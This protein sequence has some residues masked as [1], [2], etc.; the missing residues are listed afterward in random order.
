[1]KQKTIAVITSLVLV[2][3]FIYAGCEMTVNDPIR[4]VPIFKPYI[5]VHPASQSLTASASAQTV[6]L[7]VQV[8]EW[9]PLDGSLSFQWY[10]F[11]RLE[12]FY[13][14]QAQPVGSGQFFSPTIASSQDGDRY[15]YY[16]V[17]TNTNADAIGA[18]SASTVSDVAVI[19]FSG[20][21]KPAAPV[22]TQNPGNATY[23]LGRTAAA[24]PLDVRATGSTTPGTSGN[25]VALSYQWYSFKMA[26]GFN[27]TTGRPNGTLIPNALQRTYLPDM[28]DLTGGDNFYYVVVSNVEFNAGGTEV[29]RSDVYSAPANIFMEKASAA[30]N[31]RIDGQPRNVLYFVNEDKAASTAAKL[32]VTAASVDGGT[33]SY[34]WYSVNADGTNKT[35]ISANGTAATLTPP[36]ATASVGT[37]YYLV[38]V[39]NTV[40]QENV[41]EGGAVSQTVTSKIAVVS[42]AASAGTI[43]TQNMTVT[44]DRT[45]R[46]NYIRGYGGMEVAWAN[47]PETLPEDTENMYNPDKLGYNIL[48]IMMPVSN[49]D[50]NV[51]MKDLMDSHRQYYYDNVKIVN[52]YGGYVLASPWTPPKEWKSNNSING[53][54]HLIHAYYKQYANYLRSF[55]RHMAANDAPI[56]AISIQNEPNYVAG[57]DGCEWTPEEMRNFYKEVGRFTQGIRGYGGGRVTPTVLTVNGESANNPDINHA[58]IDD[59]VSFAAIDMFARHVYGNQ[60]Q[61][62]WVNRPQVQQS[63]KEVWMTE[64][65]INSA[66]ATAFPNDW[67]WN[68]IWPFMNDVDLVMRLNNENAFVWWAGKRFYSFISDGDASSPGGA[69]IVGTILPRGWGLAHYSKFTI[70]MTRVGITIGDGSTLNGQAINVNNLNS[71]SFSLDNISTRVTAY[72]SRDGKEIS[73]I[74]WTPTATSGSGGYA[75]GTVKIQLPAGFKIRSATAMRSTAGQNNQGVSEGVSIGDDRNSAVVTV[76][77]SNILSVKF[78]SE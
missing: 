29:A 36:I 38:D 11:T 67:T 41:E 52:K 56:Y 1:M 39:K 18:T 12:D 58:A 24:A 54:G 6:D 49:V 7:D 78:I 23:T 31:P 32:S 76:P 22:I 30:L 4:A 37:A 51:A 62:L 61:N 43:T 71:T 55:A 42:V 27:S 28:G 75:L 19:A 68:Y 17:V 21:G 59:P 63:G 16:V 25:S 34:Q 9:D 66:T 40:P 48:R 20:A 70:D 33:L 69:G 10:G 15:Y 26:D 35:I 77:A 47:F 73:L 72:E 74:M 57:Y 5:S 65:N 46:F 45:Q 8:W 44:V 60:Q 50:V 53:G 13:K 2:I 64:H 14:G 3:A